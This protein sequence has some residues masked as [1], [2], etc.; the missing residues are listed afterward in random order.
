L[1]ESQLRGTIGRR[2]CQ[3]NR[4]DV[5]APTRLKL[6]RSP[7][8][9]YVSNLQ[10]MAADDGDR[11]RR[12]S[13]V[14]RFLGYMRESSDERELT[15]SLIQAGAV[16]YDLDA[17]SYRRE[18]D[19]R[20]VLDGCLPGADVTSDPR[21]LDV[22]PILSPDVPTRISSINELEHYGWQSVQGEVLLLPIAGADMVRRILVVSGP[23]EREVEGT[24][25]LVCRSAGTVLDYLASK[26]GAALRERL[27]RTMAVGT[28]SFQSC[29]RSLVDEYLAAVNATA[30]RVAVLKE[31]HATVTLHAVGDW[32]SEVPAL[33]AGAAE[34][35][36]QRIALGLAL[37][38]GAVGA[39]ELVAS[40]AHPFTVERAQAARVGA[41]VLGGWLSGVSLGASSMRE[42][43]AAR[44][45]DDKAPA[46]FEDLMADELNTARRLSM[47]GGVLVAS[48]PGAAVPD[49]RVIS[50]VI[51]TVRQ[52]LRSADLLGQLAGGD[53][54]AVL[55]RTSPEGVAKAAER[56]RVRFDELVRARQLPPV[57]VAHALCPPG[58]GVSPTALVAKARKEAGL[59]FS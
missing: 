8:E 45:A 27:L 30:A 40:P 25:M 29:A 43:A 1:I 51:R 54:A 18:L 57:V 24:L 59:V 3:R 19:G 14:M 52:E 49:P 50:A 23:L 32:T 5:F 10:T 46:P 44:A 9:Y 2:R 20:F 53:V 35:T 47:S 12:L 38:N 28:G 15:L 48:V 34:V 55:V 7:G 11:L 36:T 31:S 6:D 16:W 13:A 33:A 56:V 42:R 17:R 4:G 22:D 41:E 21:E 26:R 58:A 39:I 37:G